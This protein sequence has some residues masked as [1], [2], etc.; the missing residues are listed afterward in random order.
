MDFLTVDEYQVLERVDEYSLYCFYLKFDP[1]VG[2]KYSSPLRTKDS[3]PSF[4]IYVREFGGLRAN[5]FMWKDAALSVPNFGDIFDLIIRLFK[6]VTTRPEAMFKVLGDFGYVEKYKSSAST[7]IVKEP[8][9][10]EPVDITIL[11]KSFN[12]NDMQYWKQYGVT[13]EIL[14]TYSVHRVGAYWLYKDQKIPKY[15]RQCYA[16]EIFGKYQLY[17]PF[18]HKKKKFRNNWHELCVPGLKQIRSNGLHII[19][20]AVKDIMCLRSLGFDATC[21]RGENASPH[22]MYFGWCNKTF[23]RTVTLF[24][25]D[26]KTSED[27]YPYE[28]YQ[29]P[30]ETGT[31][32]ISDF[33]AKFG[34]TETQLL[35]NRLI[36]G[37]T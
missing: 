19:T 9:Y 3:D 35:L 31:K 25:N 33:Y 12:Q 29:V 5:E 1:D 8:V 22:P 26:G 7:L 21:P 13:K 17:Q 37:N 27:K 6:E 14:A 2:A 23:K 32:D 10:A 24:D 11:K 18:E 28:S 16:Y 20:K 36:Y 15:P 4:G 34:P 30:L